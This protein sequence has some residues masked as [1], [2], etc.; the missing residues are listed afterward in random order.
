MKQRAAILSSLSLLTAQI[1]GASA[2]TVTSTADSGAGTLPGTPLVIG[3]QYLLGDE[4][5]IG[6]RFYRLK[7]P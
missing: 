6:N 1:A 5:V 4:P 2:I 3:N 7:G